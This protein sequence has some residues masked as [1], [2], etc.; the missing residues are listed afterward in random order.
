MDAFLQS[1]ELFGEVCGM[2][3]IQYGF[4]V[5]VQI[6][7]VHYVFGYGR[8]EYLVILK[9]R[10]DFLSVRFGVIFADIDA[11][12]KNFSLGRVIKTHHQLYQC[13]FPGTVI[14]YD[15]NFV[16]LGNFQVYIFQ[17]IFSVIFVCRNYIV[18]LMKT[19]LGVRGKFIR[20]ADIAKFETFKFRNICAPA[21]DLRLKT[22]EFEILFDIERMP[23]IFCQTFRKVDQHPAYA[24]YKPYACRKASDFHAAFFKQ[25]NHVQHDCKKC[26]R[27]DCFPADSV[28]EKISFA[29]FFICGNNFFGIIVIFFHQKLVC[30][31]DAKL[32][33]IIGQMI[34]A[35]YVTLFPE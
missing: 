22:H 14:A 4:F 27:P 34:Y 17:D 35:V 19:I 16:A 12:V 8:S 11:V 6:G 23:R 7:T 28:Q 20:K 18:I 5:L 15:C 29:V 9:N 26:D 3:G 21:F 1:I 13:G 10:T 32:F 2:K 33:C 30:T 24:P 31:A 25:R